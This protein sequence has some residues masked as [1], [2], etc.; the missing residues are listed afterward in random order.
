MF[1]LTCIVSVF[2]NKNMFKLRYINKISYMSIKI[3][4]SDMLYK[5]S[6]L[7]YKI[8]YMPFKISDML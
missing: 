6:E 1:M 8:S 2:I 3:S 7:A 5:I 4:I